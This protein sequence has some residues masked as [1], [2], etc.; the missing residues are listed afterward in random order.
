[1]W[2]IGEKDHERQ[3]CVRSLLVGAH[4]SIGAVKTLPNRATNLMVRRSD[5]L[6]YLPH[7]PRCNLAGACA[8]VT[9]LDEPPILLDSA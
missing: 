2:F 3:G 4:C 1:M 9:Q 8:L 7:Q 5:S 6:T